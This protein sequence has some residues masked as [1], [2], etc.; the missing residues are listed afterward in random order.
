MPDGAKTKGGTDKEEKPSCKENRG[1][2]QKEERQAELRKE[3][4]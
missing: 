2:K 4:R 1:H 3:L